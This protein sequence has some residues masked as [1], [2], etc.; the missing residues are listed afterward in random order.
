MSRLCRLADI[1]IDYPTD[2]RCMNGV[3]DSV[4]IIERK[5]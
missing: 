2:F 4:F 3:F 5:A 1:L